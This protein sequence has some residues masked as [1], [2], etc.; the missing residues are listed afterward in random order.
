M[1]K[2]AK[3]IKS[4][5]LANEIWVKLKKNKIAVFGMVII[6]CSIIVAILGPLIQPDH[7][8][9][10]NGMTLQLTTKKPGF[11]VKM[12]RVTKNREDTE[13]GIISKMLFGEEL[14][15]REIHFREN[16]FIMFSALLV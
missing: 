13:K 1:V 2:P 4:K 9:D 16:L 15:Y 5:S 6:S 7:T 14:Q 3:H 12:L 11:T 8:P 10:A